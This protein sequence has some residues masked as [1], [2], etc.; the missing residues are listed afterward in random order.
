MLYINNI[1]GEALT[2]AEMQKQFEVEYDG[3]DPCN[4]LDWREYYTEHEE[5]RTNWFTGREETGRRYSDV[6]KDI[7]EY[8]EENEDIFNECIED[9]DSYNG[10]LADD[11]YYPMEDLDEVMHGN[12]AITLLQRAYFGHDEDSWHTDSSGNK[13]YDSF[14]PN[15]EFFAFNGYGNL[16]SADYKDYSAFLDTYCIESMQK[17]RNHIYCIDNDEELSRLFDELDEC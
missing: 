8:F 13:I 1:T 7:I 6:V 15:R 14:N 9:M 12:D 10:Y 4:P 16:V 11:R 5:N 17:Y 2:W 3:N